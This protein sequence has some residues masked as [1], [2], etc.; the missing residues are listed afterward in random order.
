MQ[1]DFAIT[2]KSCPKFKR[3]TR[4]VC[5]IPKLNENILGDNVKVITCTVNADLI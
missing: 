1:T 3:R 5:E 2:D 4:C